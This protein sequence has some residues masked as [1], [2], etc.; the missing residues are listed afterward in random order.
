MMAKRKRST[1]NDPFGFG[2]GGFGNFDLGLNGYSKR[3][4][5]ANNRMKGKMAE[6]SFMLEQRMQ[7][8]DCKKIHKGGDFIVQKREILSGKKIGKPRV[9]EIKTG[10]SRL[11]KAQTR[12]K[13]RLGKGFKEV[14]YG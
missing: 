12:N 13:K 6:D 9:V 4:T 1:D 14:R 3:A 7:G 8:N 10:G 2:S 5:L 11:S